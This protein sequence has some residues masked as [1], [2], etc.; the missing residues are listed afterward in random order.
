MEV[1]LKEGDSQVTTIGVGGHR[2][3]HG[4]GVLGINDVLM[5]VSGQLQQSAGQVMMMTM[6]II[7]KKN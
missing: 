1:H 6:M 4:P 7:I 3:Q 5:A 2:L